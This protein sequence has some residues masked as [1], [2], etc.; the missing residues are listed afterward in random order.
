M[1]RLPFMLSLLL[2][3]GR[4]FAGDPQPQGEFHQAIVK[5]T[6]EE[7]RA[8]KGK[9]W[10]GAGVI[11]FAPGDQIPRLGKKAEVEAMLRTS[12]K[13]GENF[14]GRVYLPRHVGGMDEQEPVSLLYRMIVGG[15]ML[16]QVELKGDVKPDPE[17]SSWMIDLP[18]DLQKGFD[19]LASGTH[20]VRIEVWSSR[21]A[22]K[23]TLWVDENGKPLGKTQESVNKGKF[24]ASGEFNWTK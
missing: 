6:D 12:F 8:T 9:E 5:K 18:A 21:E 11:C 22:V 7:R 20:S 4:L 13:R 3:V 24:W 23:T 1:K 19:A 15:K 17:W 2:P 16:Y 10:W 14:T